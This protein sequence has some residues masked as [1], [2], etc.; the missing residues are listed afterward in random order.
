MGTYLVQRTHLPCIH[1]V[2]YTRRYQKLDSTLL[3]NLFT[4]EAWN[5]VFFLIVAISDTVQ[6]FTTVPQG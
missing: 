5:V 3:H 1:K 6:C 4:D 2:V